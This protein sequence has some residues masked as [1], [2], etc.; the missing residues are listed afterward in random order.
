MATL[1]KSELPNQDPIGKLNKNRKIRK[2]DVAK[3]KTGTSVIQEQQLAD[4]SVSLDLQRNL[5]SQLRETV[6]H[7]KEINEGNRQTMNKLD[8]FQKNSFN[9]QDLP[10]QGEEV[11]DSMC[12]EKVA[13]EYPMRINKHSDYARAIESADKLSRTID[14]L[15]KCFE[16]QMCLERRPTS[17]SQSDSVKCYPMSVVFRSG[18]RRKHICG[19]DD[20]SVALFLSG[21][22]NQDRKSHCVLQSPNFSNV[23]RISRSKNL[24]AG[25]L[26]QHPAS[27]TSTIQ[28]T[29]TSLTTNATTEEVTRT[30]TT[31]RNPEGAT[32][33][34]YP[35]AGNI[36]GRLRRK[37]TNIQDDNRIVSYEAQ[38]EGRTYKP[39][40]KN[41]NDGGFQAGIRQK[42]LNGLKEIKG[43]G[44]QFVQDKERAVMRENTIPE[45]NRNSDH[46]PPNPSGNSL[47]SDQIRV[48][49]KHTGSRDMELS[50]DRINICKNKNARESVSVENVG[51][52]HKYSKRQA[53][54]TKQSTSKMDTQDRVFSSEIPKRHEG[55]EEKMSNPGIKQRNTN[56][57][58]STLA[59]TK[60]YNRQ[61]GGDM[62]MDH[63]DSM[64]ASELPSA[65]GMF[66]NKLFTIEPS[67][68]N[69][70]DKSVSH[71]LKLLKTESVATGTLLASK[72][73][74]KKGI[75]RDKNSTSSV[76]KK[77]NDD[78][79]E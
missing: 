30:I 29:A 69:N 58:E 18:L 19:K 64:S 20:N 14:A 56:S 39:L 4:D 35:S 23:F 16:E 77:R 65:Q 5:I 47:D 40:V 9:E 55:T 13:V 10:K 76:P 70:G 78:K 8:H 34:Q 59:N 15:R 60:N 71:T 61:E 74:I 26:Q 63:E 54:V 3:T 28:M 32:F 73:P 37:Q 17:P 31:I 27:N 44:H 7:V 12:G 57:T 75:T 6:T 62:K 49:I 66:R 43:T 25:K 68:N 38:I 36:T 51:K 33:Q 67:I 45:E 24:Q 52:G 46:G 48:S 79:N 1:P 11:T 41:T 72:P 21:G 50:T 53:S 42:S 22:I 2:A